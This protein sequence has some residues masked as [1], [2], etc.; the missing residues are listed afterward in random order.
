MVN[1][2]V[3][4]VYPKSEYV[5]RAGEIGEEMYFI[6]QGYCKVVTSDGLEL[7]TIK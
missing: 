6:I 4:K 5:I 7:A 1:K 3:L 2:L